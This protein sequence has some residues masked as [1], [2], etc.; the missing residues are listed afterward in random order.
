MPSDVSWLAPI[1]K[2][3]PKRSYGS[4]ELADLWNTG[5]VLIEVGVWSETRPRN[6]MRV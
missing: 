3:R 1:Y 4:R 2:K 5:I 6:R